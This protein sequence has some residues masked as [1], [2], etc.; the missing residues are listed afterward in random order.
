MML[1]INGILIGIVFT[2]LCTLGLVLLDYRK[3]KIA[4]LES[5]QELL[6]SISTA[7]N[8][9]TENIQTLDKKINETALKVDMA[10]ARKTNV[11][12]LSNA[13]ATF[14]KPGLGL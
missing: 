4:E 7:H 13:T 14:A 12:H 11:P 9:L 2:L 3:K 6:K 5:L 8:Q 1:A 10:I